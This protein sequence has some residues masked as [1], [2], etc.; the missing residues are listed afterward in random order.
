M[1]CLLLFIT[2]KVAKLNKAYSVLF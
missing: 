2:A 1:F